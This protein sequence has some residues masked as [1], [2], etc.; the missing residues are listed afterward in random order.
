MPFF[1]HAILLFCA[2]HILCAS[3][4]IWASTPHCKEVAKPFQFLRCHPQQLECPSQWTR[5]WMLCWISLF[6]FLLIPRFLSNMRFFFN[7][8][9]N[10]GTFIWAIC[11]I[12]FLLHKACSESLTK[13]FPTAGCQARS[14]CGQQSFGDG[15]PV[16]AV[17]ENFV[18]LEILRPAKY[19]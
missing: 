13:E 5:A 17:G 11:H 3:H 10:A 4:I 12:A 8:Q 19:L 18:R 2:S 16:V 6:W 7:Q 1:V 15:P 14:K 9:A